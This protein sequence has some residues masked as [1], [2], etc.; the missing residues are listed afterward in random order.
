[1]KNLFPS[2][3]WYVRKVINPRCIIAFFFLV[4]LSGCYVQRGCGDVPLKFEKGDILRSY[5]DSSGIEH[6]VEPENVLM[7]DYTLSYDTIHLKEKVN[8]D[9]FGST[10]TTTLDIALSDIRSISV[11]PSANRRSYLSTGPGIGKGFI[12]NI[13]YTGTGH[14][15]GVH[16]GYT[17]MI[18]DAEDTPDDYTGLFKY[19]N[20][21]IISLM[22]SFGGKLSNN[23]D[24]FAGFE[25]GPSYVSHKKETYTPNPDYDPYNLHFR[26]Y[27][28]DED[29]TGV[30]G[31][32][33]R[34][35]IDYKF[36]RLLGIQL[37]LFSNFNS[38]KSTL[39]FQI[40]IIIGR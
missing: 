40:Q 25:L 6:R 8:Q 14:I 28:R 11:F 31:L 12:Y 24:I 22:I 1:M 29:I 2:F 15:A 4:L 17:G 38:S 27:F 18:Y 23:K 9:K 36:T 13:G 34:V 16:I 26:R 21:N 3:P 39:G 19:D 35:K 5:T 10:S 7:D 33:S 32:S 20:L 37:S 30:V